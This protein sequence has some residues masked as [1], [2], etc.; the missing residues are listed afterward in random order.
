MTTNDIGT[1][2]DR[3]DANGGASEPETLAKAC[4]LWQ[5]GQVVGSSLL[6][7]A[8]RVI[9][10]VPHYFSA[11]F[12]TE[13][14][15]EARKNEDALRYGQSL[16][17][18]IS[19][20]EPLDADAWNV[21]VGLSSRGF[22]GR[23]LKP[24]GTKDAQILRVLSSGE[25]VMPLWGVSLHRDVAGSFG[26]GFLFEIVGPFPAIAAW[27]HSGIK[28]EEQELIAGG[29]YRVESIESVG[30]TTHARFRWAGPVT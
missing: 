6:R 9:T 13:Y 20:S 2:G 24:N 25:I 28:A 26:G 14:E 21:A 27:T 19:A 5:T 29:R 30:A 18:A 12:I 16:L 10:G 8:A 17:G 22:A 4:E 1:S 23:G 7:G 15:D 3:T 11:D